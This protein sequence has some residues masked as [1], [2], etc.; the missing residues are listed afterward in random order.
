MEDLGWEIGEEMD[1][2]RMLRIVHMPRRQTLL[3]Q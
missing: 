1:E 3:G 2:T